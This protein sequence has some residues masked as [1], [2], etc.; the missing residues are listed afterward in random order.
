VEREE[1]LGILAL[2]PAEAKDFAAV[3]TA[4]HRRMWAVHPDRNPA[5]NA[6]EAAAKVGEAYGL[7]ERAYRAQ[8]SARMTRDA[9]AARTQPAGDGGS[10]ARVL[11]DT[12]VTAMG[13]QVDVFALARRAGAI[14]GEVSGVDAS[15]GIIVVVAEFLHMAPCQITLTVI[16]RGSDRVHVRCSVETLSSGDAPPVAAVT[17]LVA[18]KMVEAAKPHA[19]TSSAAS[20]A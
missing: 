18:Q 4:Y 12:T 8:R 2:T 6:S 9:A 11:N 16:K 13:T 17:R 19:D 14:I 1:A 7:L 15:S 5:P 10:R 3:R 20:T